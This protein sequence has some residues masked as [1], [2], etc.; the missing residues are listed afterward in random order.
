VPNIL[1]TMRD[2]WRIYHQVFSDSY[3]LPE[4]RGRSS[5]DSVSGE[6]SRT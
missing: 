1:A 6:G 3:D 4:G 2:M 5:S